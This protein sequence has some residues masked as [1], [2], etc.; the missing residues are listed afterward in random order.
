MV[1]ADLSGFGLCGRALRRAIIR[2]APNSL[3]MANL[4]RSWQ[5]S[6]I[7]SL[8]CQPKSLS[9]LCIATKQSLPGSCPTKIFICLTSA[10]CSEERGLMFCPL[11]CVVSVV[12]K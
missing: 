10:R 1:V 4:F 2:L 6:P 7:R 5:C 11:P 9:N 12:L 3:V 8:S